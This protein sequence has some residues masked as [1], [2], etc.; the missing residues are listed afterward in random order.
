MRFLLFSDSAE[1]VFRVRKIVDPEIDSLVIIKDESIFLK[2][3]QTSIFDLFLIDMHSERLLTNMREKAH[4]CRLK[5]PWILFN[6]NTS[7][8]NN[9]YMN[10]WKAFNGIGSSLDNLEEALEKK[11]E[12]LVEVISLKPKKQGNYLHLSKNANKLFEFFVKHPN[13]SISSEILQMKLFG[14]CSEKKQNELYVLIHEIR[15]AIGDDLKHPQNL[16][17]C[18]KSHYKLFNAFP[19]K[20]LDIC[21]Y[22]QRVENDCAKYF[23]EFYEITGY[24]I[25]PP[26]ENDEYEVSV[27]NEPEYLPDAEFIS[28]F[29]CMAGESSGGC[30]K[31]CGIP[32]ISEIIEAYEDKPETW[33]R[34]TSEC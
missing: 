9:N 24:D 10:Y 5:T 21:C 33:L 34:N 2:I 18:R 15:K 23:P 11:L 4:E 6:I 32:S 16:I 25:F 8:S 17:R 1:T 12:M 31:S 26:V 20:T 27:M 30:F 22:G 28:V 19:Q 3:V 13:K 7:L 14:Q 29:D